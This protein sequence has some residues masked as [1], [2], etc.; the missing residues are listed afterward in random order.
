MNLDPFG[1]N[2]DRDLWKVL[3]MAHLKAYVANL[4]NGLDFQVSLNCMKWTWT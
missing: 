1:K 3:E 4:L 2:S